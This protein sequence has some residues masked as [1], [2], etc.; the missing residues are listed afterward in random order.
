MRSRQREVKQGN[1]TANKTETGDFRKVCE[2][3]QIK[4]KKKIT[5]A[6]I[7]QSFKER[8]RRWLRRNIF[9]HSN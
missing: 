6:N 7:V 2:I 5:E 4:R 8:L 1:Y 3:I 9:N